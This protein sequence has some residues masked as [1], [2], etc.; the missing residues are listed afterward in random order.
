MLKMFY[1]LVVA[2]TNR[3]D[4]LVKK[5]ISVVPC[6]FVGVLNC[7]GLWA[8]GSCVVRWLCGSVSRSDRDPETCG[9]P[10][11]R[12]RG[13]ASR[14]KY[15]H[16]SPASDRRLARRA[17]VPNTSTRNYSR[18]LAL[19]PYPACG[20]LHENNTMD[21]C[22]ASSGI[23]Q[24]LPTLPLHYRHRAGSIYMRVIVI[25]DAAIVSRWS[26]QDAAIIVSCGLTVASC[27]GVSSSFPAAQAA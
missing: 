20:G 22:N 11:E 19:G 3:L 6:V 2:G 24:C 13:R 1:E 10:R 25:H 15:G 23:L 21:L 9:D 12:P 8:C 14:D 27:P 16:V 17:G 5:A 4:K 18:G 7:L 26:F